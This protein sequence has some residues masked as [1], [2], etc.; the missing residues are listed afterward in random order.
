MKSQSAIFSEGTLRF[1]QALA[2]NNSKAWMDKNR[3]WYRSSVVEPFRT[4]LDALSPAVLQLDPDFDINYRTGTNFSRINRD[5]RFARD[6]TPYHTHMYLYF[7]VRSTRGGELYL[8]LSPEFATAGFRI[9]SDSSD[10]SSAIETLA[11]A[12][13]AAR[14]QWLA[15]QKRR[16]GRRYESYWYAMEKREWTKHG[17][18]RRS[19]PNGKI[20]WPGLCAE[21][22]RPWPPR[23]PDSRNRSPRSFA[24]FFLCTNSRLSPMPSAAPKNSGELRRETPHGLARIP[25]LNARIL[26]L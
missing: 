14:P 4:M 21:K 10:K 2:Q 8:G 3:D 13:V 22:C 25:T 12:R 6:K 18:G 1:F 24:K 5:I 11:R 19:P 9:Y 23:A 17:A 26:A 15:Q 16:L 7:C 20:F